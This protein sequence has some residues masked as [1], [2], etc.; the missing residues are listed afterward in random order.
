MQSTLRVMSLKVNNTIRDAAAVFLLHR[1]N[2][3]NLTDEWNYVMLSDDKTQIVEY[4][5]GQYSQDPSYE[6]DNI[7]S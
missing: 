7:K 3:S 5:L 6:D 1:D 4:L 2:A